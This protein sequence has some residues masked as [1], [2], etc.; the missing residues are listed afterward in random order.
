MSKTSLKLH[1]KDLGGSFAANGMM[2]GSLAA[3]MI[4][5]QKFL[6]A[7]AIATQFKMTPPAAVV[8]YQGGIKAVGSILLLHAL[9]KKKLP[10]AAKLAIVGVGIQG[11]IQQLVAVSSGKITQI[12]KT[13][14]DLEMDEAAKRI[15]E[16]MNG[17]GITNPTEQFIPSVAGMGI[18]NPTEQF[19]PSVAGMDFVP[20]KFAGA[21]NVDLNLATGVGGLGYGADGF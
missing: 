6:D 20:A 7:N 9:R 5:S 19:I 15:K 17:M 4:V 13:P 11:L 2:M 18:Q 8:Q 10:D 3:G 21:P 14:L 1:A 16:G 12:G